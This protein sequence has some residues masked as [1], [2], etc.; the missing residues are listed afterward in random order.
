[1]GLDGYLSD[2]KILD[3]SACKT[4][5]VR[6]VD[7]RDLALLLQKYVKRLFFVCLE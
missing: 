4:Y 7:L 2:E 3:M 5:R 6:Y 1:M